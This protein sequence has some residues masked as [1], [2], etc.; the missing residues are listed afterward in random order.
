MN[1]DFKDPRP[2]RASTLQE[3]TSPVPKR[4]GRF[5]R[6]ERMAREQEAQAAARTSRMLKEN[7]S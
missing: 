2:L 4:E 7:L 1:I 5:D 6:L 3:K